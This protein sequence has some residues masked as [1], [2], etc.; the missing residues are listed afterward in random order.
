M[1]ERLNNIIKMYFD[2]RTTKQEQKILGG[3]TKG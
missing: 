3:T 1:E 2:E